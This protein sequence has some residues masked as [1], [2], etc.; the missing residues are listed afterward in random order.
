MQGGGLGGVHQTGAPATAL[1][2]SGG[3]RQP[4]HRQPGGAAQCAQVSFFRAWIF[5]RG[6]LRHQKNVGFS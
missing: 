3:A 6:T 1:Q 2:D 5:R 4:V